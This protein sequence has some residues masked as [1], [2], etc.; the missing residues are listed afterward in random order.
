MLGKSDVQIS[1][2]HEQFDDDPFDK[3]NNIIAELTL[4]LV[5]NDHFTNYNK[6]SKPILSLCKFVL[7]LKMG[8]PLFTGA[9]CAQCTDYY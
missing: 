5:D 8:V 9:F 4:F 1:T 7:F 3:I 2:V 6:L